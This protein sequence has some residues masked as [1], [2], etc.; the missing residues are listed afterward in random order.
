[1]G[2]KECNELLSWLFIQQKE[3]IKAFTQEKAIYRRSGDDLGRIVDLTYIAMADED[4]NSG[5]EIINYVI[6]N[7]FTPQNRLQGNQMLMQME[8]VIG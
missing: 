1:M 6:E 4:Y 2:N 3:Y 5:R 8:V 7:S